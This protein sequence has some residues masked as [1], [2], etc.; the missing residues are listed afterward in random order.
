MKYYGLQSAADLHET[1]HLL[2]SWRNELFAVNV[3]KS[4]IADCLL[5]DQ[6][7]PDPFHTVQQEK[8]HIAQSALKFLTIFQPQ[9]PDS[10]R[11][12]TER[13]MMMI[14]DKAL[15]KG[16]VSLTEL[17]ISGLK[18]ELGL[19]KNARTAQRVKILLSFLTALA[20]SIIVSSL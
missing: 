12:K 5:H 1:V 8:N 17:Y 3:K 18:T 4:I 10:F 6:L 19:I 20:F 16:D 2:E 15:F 14:M 11:R 13:K 7:Q 9:I